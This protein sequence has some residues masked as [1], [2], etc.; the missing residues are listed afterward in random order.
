[1]EAINIIYQDETLLI[2]NKPSGL[3]SI[4]DGYN[5]S[6]PHIK[7]ELED[8]FGRLWLVH[9]LDKESSGVMVLAKTA[10]AHKNLNLQFQNRQV[11][12]RYHCLANPV[13]NWKTQ[14]VNQPLLINSGRRHLTR[15]D[16]NKGKPATSHFKCLG[17]NES[18][19]LLE[20]HIESGY[21]HQIR[22]HLYYLGLGILGDPLYMPPQIRNSNNSF[23]RMML[24]ASQLCFIHP[25]T[26]QKVCYQADLPR[27]FFEVLGK[28]I[29]ISWDTDV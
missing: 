9:R 24:H 2:I 4:P 16:H 20:C 21:R 10:E 25:N 14:T 18:I 17:T 7:T 23:E 5:Q 28:V 1:M 12:K 13:P 27:L 19:A 15:V 29:P 22:A 6:L 26:M 3:L 11:F 8:L